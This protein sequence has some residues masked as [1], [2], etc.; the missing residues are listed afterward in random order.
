MLRGRPDETEHRQFEQKPADELSHHR[1]LTQPLRR[2]AHQPA[3][4]QQQHE[5]GVKIAPELPE[6]ALSAAIAAVGAT[7]GALAIKKI[8]VH[9]D[10]HR[11]GAVRQTG[12]NVIASLFDQEIS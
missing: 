7:I 11:A 8:V 10:M 1:R 9:G 12:R 4:H 3:D 5:L 6:A 2:L